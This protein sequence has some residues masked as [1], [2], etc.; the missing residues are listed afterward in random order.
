MLEYDPVKRISAGDALQHPWIKTHASG[1]K[2]ERTLASK[3]LNNL[4]NFRVS[5]Y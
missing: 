5:K 3:T 4:K 2:V 1:E